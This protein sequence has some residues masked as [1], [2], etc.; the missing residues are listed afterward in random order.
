MSKIKDAQSTRRQQ[1]RATTEER[2]RAYTR[3][4]KSIRDKLQQEIE[5]AKKK[6]I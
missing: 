4:S 5:K 1:N 3:A 6:S 2:N